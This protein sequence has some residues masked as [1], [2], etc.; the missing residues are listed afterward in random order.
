MRD[1]QKGLLEPKERTP[2][3]KNY[4]VIR[5]QRDIYIKNYKKQTEKHVLIQ[6]VS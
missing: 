5:V 6:F 4:T 2:G 1:R 3:Q